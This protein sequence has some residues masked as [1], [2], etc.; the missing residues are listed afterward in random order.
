MTLSNRAPEVNGQCAVRLTPRHLADLRASGLSDE[1]IS[2]C[3]FRSL[4]AAG[5]VEKVLRWQGYG[6]SLG[7]CLAIPFFDAAG[8]PID[9]SRLKPDR[10]RKSNEDGNP[11]KYESPKGSSNRAYFPPGTRAALTDPSAPLIVTEGE[12]K[13]AKADQ[14]GFPCVG[15]VGVYGWQK[16]RLRNADGKPQGDR[17]LIDDLARIA[18]HGPDEEGTGVYARK[19]DAE[20][21]A[22]SGQIPVSFE[23]DPGHV[24][25]G[26][27]GQG[28]PSA[29][30]NAAGEFA[31]SWVA[32]NEPDGG[33]NNYAHRFDASGQ[34]VGNEFR[35]NSYTGWIRSNPEVAMDAAGDLVAAW[36]SLPPPTFSDYPDTF[37]QAY[38][39]AGDAVGPNE[40]R[41]NT[42]NGAERTANVAMNAAGDFVV[43]W[44]DVFSERIRGQRY[45]GGFNHAGGQ[46]GRALHRGRGRTSVARCLEFERPEPARRLTH[47]PVGLRRGQGLRRRHG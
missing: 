42:S 10:P 27:G 29:A 9:Y 37:A 35:V 23:Y 13:S 20:G 19:Y 18:W 32:F 36:T 21:Q 5:D 26:G 1:Q 16:K 11:I 43:T 46:C 34:P 3:G 39:A 8:K 38:T 41:V 47:L 44:T 22:L 14:E 24:E 15:L 2:A 30:I 4:R 7:D 33:F 40:F 12:K 17:E 31:I 6:E 25:P 45:S 28:S